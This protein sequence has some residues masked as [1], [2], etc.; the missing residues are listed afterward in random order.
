MSFSLEWSIKDLPNINAYIEDLVMRSDSLEAHFEAVKKLFQWLSEVN[1]TVKLSQASKWDI[2]GL[3]HWP[4]ESGPSRCKDSD[5]I[6]LFPQA[7]FEAIFGY[8]RILPKVLQDLYFVSS[9]SY[10]KN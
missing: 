6:F 10:M 5:Y 3:C 7:S 9:K 1:L 4:R 8:G 2:F